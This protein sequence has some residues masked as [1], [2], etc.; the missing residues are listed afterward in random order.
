MSKKLY[1]AVLAAGLMLPGIGFA[2][3]DG[4]TGKINSAITSGS[5]DAIIAELERAENIPTTGA[6][7]SVLKLV[8]HQSDRVRE[9][10]GWWL[11][12]RA[13][14]NQIVQLAEVRLNG[15]DPTAARNV[16]DVLRGMRDVTRLAEAVYELDS[17]SAPACPVSPPPSTLAFT[18]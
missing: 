4:S 10:A 8:D 11:G 16:L 2:G 18:S 7:G 13:A 1:A 5:V 9:A 3:V 15:Q 12:R 6:V 17:L 14:R